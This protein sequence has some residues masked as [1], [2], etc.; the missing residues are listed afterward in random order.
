MD[1]TMLQQPSRRG[2]GQACIFPPLPGGQPSDDEA[3]T[4]SVDWHDEMAAT[5]ND[6]NAAWCIL[7]YLYSDT[8]EVCFGCQRSGDGGRA[9]SSVLSYTIRESDTLGEIATALSNSDGVREKLD[10]SSNVS[11]NTSTRFTA[12]YDDRSS[13]NQ[14]GD[15]ATGLLM[16][17]PLLPP[18]VDLALDVLENHDGTISNYRMIY[19]PT[20]MSDDEAQN[21]AATFKHILALL[22][23]SPDQQ[24]ATLDPSERDVDHIMAW[25][26]YPGT[27]DLNPDARLVH[28]VFREQVRSRPS[29]V[30]IDAWDGRL[31]YAELDDASDRLRDRLRQAGLA[32][33]D[34]VLLCF[35]KSVWMSVAMLAV[36]KTGAFCSSLDPDYPEHRVTQIAEATEAAFLVASQAQLKKLRGYEIS[37]QL[38]LVQVPSNI[39]DEHELDTILQNESRRTKQKQYQQQQTRPSPDSTAFV[40]F[41]SGSTGVPKGI[42]VSHA[43]VCTAVAALGDAFGVDG[44]TRTV[45][46]AAHSWDVSVQDYLGSLLRGATVCVPSDNERWNDLEGYM[47]RTA[48]NWA[49]LTPTVARTLRPER[50]SKSLRTLLLVGEPMGDAD[51]AGWVEAGTRAFNVYGCTEA[52]WVQVSRPKTGAQVGRGH[53]SGYGINTRVW[54]VRRGD[55]ALSPVGC[56]GEIWLEG[57]M[58]TQGY[59]NVDPLLEQRSFP[60]RPDWAERLLGRTHDDGQ[61]RFYRT[62]DLGRL[63][64]DGALEVMGR[65]DTQAKLGGQRLELSEVEHY[66]RE[67]SA[68]QAASVFIPKAG[69]F[70]GRLT[71]VLGDL[72][73]GGNIEGG[74]HHHHLQLSKDEED[75]EE[76]LESQLVRC[77]PPAAAEIA[78]KLGKA[79]PSFMVPAA[80]MSISRF[81]MTASGKLAR[82]RILSQLET[83]AGVS[84]DSAQVDVLLP[85]TPPGDSTPGEEAF[86]QH[87]CASLLGIEPASVDLGKSFVSLGGDSIRAMQIVA[88]YRAVGKRI[89]VGQLFN[90]RCLLEVAAQ[91]EGLQ[92]VLADSKREYGTDEDQQPSEQQAVSVMQGSAVRQQIEHIGEA[93]L[94]LPTINSLDDVKDVFPLSPMQ[95]SLALSLARL[96]GRF[97]MDEFVWEVQAADGSRIDMDRLGQAWEAVVA[98][99]Q[100]LRTVFVEAEVDADSLDRTMTGSSMPLYQVVLRRS[101]ASCQ[102]VRAMSDDDVPH[103]AREHPRL[104]DTL[105]HHQLIHAGL[106]THSMLMVY[107]DGDGDG[108]GR[109]WCR[110][111]VSHLVEDAMSILPLLRDVSLAYRY[112]T[113]GP[114]PG[115]GIGS[116]TVGGE[117]VRYI[118]NRERHEA[119]LAYWSSHL[120]GAQPCLFPSLVDSSRESKPE[121][122]SDDVSSGG[123]HQEQRVVQVALNDTTHGLQQAVAR[124]GLT[125]PTF[126]QTIWAL[127]L[128]IYS[129]KIDVVFGNV[130]SGRD[131]PVPDIEEA[132]GS[133]LGILVCRVDLGR[134]RQKDDDDDDDAG[135]ETEESGSP[136]G[137]TLLGIMKEIQR[138]TIEG[139]SNQSCSLAEMQEAAGLLRDRSSRVPLFNSGISCRPLITESDQ[140]DFALRFRQVESR[141]LTEMDLALIVETGQDKMSVY[142]QYQPS[143]MS[144]AAAANVAETVS[145]LVTE[146]LL[147]PRRSVHDVGKVSPRDLAQIWDWNRE[148]VPP[149][150]EVMHSFVEE[151]MRASPGRQA[152][153]SWDGDMTYGELDRATGCVAQYLRDSCGVVPDG[154]VPICSEKSIWAVV[155]MLGVMRA[156]GCF[157]MLD[158]G[159]PD[160]R[161]LSIVEQVRP[162]VMLSSLGQRARLERWARDLDLSKS[163]DDGPPSPISVQV[164]AITDD[165]IKRR[166]AMTEISGLAICICPEVRPR[167]AMY[168]QFTSGTTG[169]PKGVV[170]SHRNFA[171]GFRRHCAATE[172]WPHTRALQFSAYSFDSSVGEILTTLAV[173]GCLCS[174]SDED[175]SMAIVAFIARSGANWAAWTPSFASLIDPDDVPS[176]DAMCLAGEPLSASLVDRWADRVRMVNI[177]G[178]SEC[179]MAS[180]VNNPVT[181]D[182]LP[183]NIGRAHR[184]VTWI[185]DEDD[186]ERLQ[187]IGAVGELLIE[188]PVVADAGYLGRPDVTSRVFIGAPSWLRSGPHSRPGA[189][190]YKTGDLVRYSSDGSI[191]YVGRKDTQ[192]KIHGQRV[193]VGDIEQHLRVCMAQIVQGGIGVASPPPVAV[194]LLHKQEEQ[195]HGSEVLAAFIVVGDGDGYAGES[196]DASCVS[197]GNRRQQ[198]RDRGRT[199]LDLVASDPRALAGF[200]SLVERIRRSTL[201]LPS[202]M[203]PRIFVPLKTLPTTTAG[204][205]DRRA[206]H[207]VAADMGRQR[208]VAFSVQPEPGSDNSGSRSSS[209]AMITDTRAEEQQ[210]PRDSEPSS[211][212]D[213]VTGFVARLLGLDTV[214]IH[215]DFFNLGGNSVVAI[216]L[217]G[218]ARRHNLALSV[219]DIFEKPRIIDMVARITNINVVGED[220]RVTGNGSVHPQ[221]DQQDVTPPPFQLLCKSSVLPP[222]TSSS[223]SS[224][225]EFVR[226]VATECGMAVADIEDVFPCTPLQEN[227]M[228]ISTRRT[229]TTTSLQPYV[230]QQAFLLSDR[231][232]AARL[233]AA[234]RATLSKHGL[235]RSRIVST[236][237][238]G[239][240]VMAKKPDPS[241]C[242]IHHHAG[243]LESYLTE[244]QTQVRF[245]YGGPLIRVAFVYCSEAESS[246]K[247][248]TT[249]RTNGE[250]RGYVIFRAHHSIYDGW[251]LQL[252]W[253][254]VASV[255]SQ[256]QPHSHTSINRNMINMDTNKATSSPSFQTFVS[257]VQ[258][259]T[260][261]ESEKFWRETLADADEEDSSTLF[262]AVPAGHQPLARAKLTRVLPRRPQTPRHYS[263]SSVTVPTLVQAAW[264]LVLALYGGTTSVTFGAVLSGRD[265]PMPGIEQL[266]GPTMATVPRHFRVRRD[267]SIADFL[268][269]AHRTGLASTAHQHLGLDGI[270]RLGPGPRAACDFR[271][272]VVVQPAEYSD[273][274]SGAQARIGIRNVDDE[275]HNPAADDAFHPYPLNVEFSLLRDGRVAV[276]V[277]FDPD[278]VEEHRVDSMVRCFDS[279][280]RGIGQSA[281]DD[282]LA[283]IMQDLHDDLGSAVSSPSPFVPFTEHY[284]RMGDVV[285]YRAARRQDSP[286]LVAT[287]ASLTYRELETRATRLARRLLASRHCLSTEAGDDDDGSTGDN[288]KDRFVAICMPKSPL[289]VVAMLAI[290]KA[291]AAFT[292]LNTSHPPSRLTSI[293]TRA[294]ASLVLCSRS[295]ST[296]FDGVEGVEVWV[297][298]EES[299][300]LDDASVAE[301]DEDDY[302]VLPHTAHAN[303]YNNNTNTNNNNNNNTSI[304]K[305]PHPDDAA[306]LLFTSGSTG[307]PKGVVV[308][309]RAL[310]SGMAAQA[311]AI[312]CTSETRML[313]CAN[314]AFDASIL[315]IFAPLSVGGCVCLPDDAERM[316]D[317]AGFIRRHDV[318]ACTFTPSLLRLLDPADVP[319]L[320]TIVSGGEPLT[321]TDIEA[322]LGRLPHGEERHMYNVYGVTEACVVS[323]AMPMALSTSPRT[324]GYPVG[325]SL[326][327]VSPVSGMLAPPGAVGEL[328]LEGPALARGY[329]EDRPRTQ[330][331][332]VDDPA[333]LVDGVSRPRPTRV[334]R[335]G[336]L[337]Y[338]NGDGSL[339]FLGRRDGQVK[340]RGQ[341]V[342]PDEVANMIRG[343]I[344]SRR[345]A[346]STPLLLLPNAAVTSFRPS[347][348]LVAVIP[349][350]QP[351]Q[352]GGDG[353]DDDVEEYHPVYD[354]EGVACSLALHSALAT[355]AGLGNK[356]GAA[357]HAGQQ[358]QQQQQQQHSALSLEAAEL[359]AYL[360]RRI[361]EVIV[362]RAYI[363]VNSMP[364]TPSGKLD[365]R[366]VHRCLETLV[367]KHGLVFRGSATT[368]S[369]SSTSMIDAGPGIT[370]THHLSGDARLLQEC[371]AEVLRVHP[372][373]LIGEEADFFHMGGSSVTAIR[374]ISLL[375]SRGRLLTYEAVVMH[376]QLGDMAATL[377]PLGGEQL[378]S[379][380][381]GEHLGVPRPFEMVGG[382]GAKLDSILDELMLQYGIDRARVCDVYPCTPMQEAFMAMSVMHQGAYVSFQTLEVPAGQFTNFQSAWHSI[383]QRHELLRTRIVPWLG[384]EDEATNLQGPLPSPSTALQVVIA[385]KYETQDAYWRRAPDVDSFVRDVNESHGYGER[386]V[387]LA[388]VMAEEEEGGDEKTVQ[389]IIAAH[390]A[391]YDGFSMAMLWQELGVEMETL[392]KRTYSSTAGGVVDASVA[393]R[394]PPFSTYIRHLCLLSQTDEPMVFWRETLRG[395]SDGKLF[396]MVSS[397]VSLSSSAPDSDPDPDPEDRRPAASSTRSG[398]AVLGN[399]KSRSKFRLVDLAHAAW[400]L[401]VSHYTANPDVVFGV[402]SSGRESIAGLPDLD[403]AVL[404][405]PTMA[406]A[407]LRL[408]VDYA[409]PTHDYLDDVRQKGLDLARFAHVGLQRISQASSDARRACR[410]ESIVVVQP[411]SPSLSISPSEAVSEDAVDVEKFLSGIKQVQT[412]AMY[413]HPLMVECVPLPPNDAG[414]REVR[415][416]LGYDPRMVAH[417]LAHRVLLTFTGIMSQL[418]RDDAMDVPLSNLRGLS[419]EDEA[420]LLERARLHTPKSVEACVH[421]LVRRQTDLHANDV[422]VDAWDG[423]LTYAELTAASVRLASRLRDKFGDC[424]G[425]AFP[426]LCRKSNGTGIRCVDMERCQGNPEEEGETP[427]HDPNPNPTSSSTPTPSDLAY[428]LFTSGSTGTPKGVMVEHR[429]LSSSLVALG[430]SHDMTPATR[431]M[432]FASYAFDAMLVEIWSTLA[433]GGCVCVPSDQQRMNDITGF[434]T[435]A[436]VNHLFCTPSLS[437]TIPP[438]AV[439]PWPLQKVSLGGEAMSQGDVDRWCSRGAWLSNGYGP[440]EACIAS[441]VQ[442]MTQATPIGTVG[443]PLD[444]CR[445]WVVNPLKQQQQQQ[446]DQ[447]YHPGQY[448]LAPIGAIGELYIEGVNVARGYLHDDA[449]TAAAF[450]ERPPWLDGRRIEDS[451]GT[452]PDDEKHHRVYRTGDLAYYNPDG[453]LRLVGRKDAQVKLRGQRVELGEIEEAIRQRIPP[454]ITVAVRSFETAGHGDNREE[455]D[456]DDDGTGRFSDSVTKA[457]PR[458]SMLLA[459]FGVGASPGDDDDAAG[460]QRGTSVVKDSDTLLAMRE[461]ISR[462]QQDLRAVLPTYM[463]PDGYVPLQSLPFNSSGKLDER[464][465]RECIGSLTPDLIASFSSTS[466]GFPS[467][468]SDATLSE[469]G[470][471]SKHEALLAGLWMRLLSAYSTPEESSSSNS[472]NKNTTTTRTTLRRGDDFF[473]LGGDSITAMRL[474]ALARRYD[475][476]LTWRDIVTNPTLSAMAGAMRVNTSTNDDESILAETYHGAAADEWKAEAFKA[477]HDARCLPAGVDLVDVLPP[478]PVQEDF[479]NATVSFPGAH[480]SSLVFTLDDPS[481]DVARLQSAF[482]RCAVWFPILRTRLVRVSMPP[483]PRVGA[484]SDDDIGHDVLVQIV[485]AEP[486]AWTITSSGSLEEALEAEARTPPGLGQALSRLRVV[487]QQPDSGEDNTCGGGRPTHLIWTQHHSSY[488]GWSVRLLLEHVVKAYVDEAYQPPLLS[489]HLTFS[490]FATHVRRLNQ[491]TSSLAFWSA[492][493]EGARPRSL[494]N[495]DRVADPRRSQT[496][497]RRVP[498]PACE[499]REGSTVTTATYIVAAWATVVGRLTS[500]P[501]DVTLGYTLSGRAGPLAGIEGTVGPVLNKIPLRIRVA[502]DEGEKATAKPP[503]FSAVVEA[504]Q[505]ALLLVSDRADRPRDLEG[506]VPGNVKNLPLD[507]VVHPRGTSGG[508][509]LLPGASIGLRA[510]RARLAAPAP[511]A[512]SVE[513]AISDDGIEVVALWDE[514]AVTREVVDDTVDDFA[515]LL[516]G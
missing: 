185:V 3:R 301:E 441:T 119:S 305:S 507:L 28:E 324:V 114:G 408:H 98:R 375:R 449:K 234:W 503:A 394:R 371:W 425:R 60:N 326:W 358:R 71:A 162:R 144:D 363:A 140:E 409:R 419:A 137:P 374:L 513:V 76:A 87:V 164:L 280:C 99:H 290:W 509:D 512:F 481:L 303:A 287:G 264:A 213:I 126:F 67:A 431:T 312:R 349:S 207:R 36:L 138:A 160:S 241:Q 179:S 72:P 268:S 309:H 91:V 282:T 401:T 44:A 243:S 142:L 220:S 369:L 272:V 194:E 231:V 403:P 465:L 314:F 377:M 476:G 504:T 311:A 148:C 108:R 382:D 336:D 428:I 392:G 121:H 386:L 491:L 360:R 49:H 383:H 318:N 53:V 211:V 10:S 58:V 116:L 170:I 350:S 411:A 380:Q 15:T 55:Q 427:D 267:Q 365:A 471:L 9:A 46:F 296:V 242:T 96:G 385:P 320:R 327:L 255:Y 125:L 406:S 168:V 219:A 497:K 163:K 178:P 286:A 239:V 29:W 8:D 101:P 147:N 498:L 414:H 432:Q 353:D 515:A 199:S 250:S 467:S 398:T 37:Q 263:D 378:L 500:L 177:Y 84:Y 30:A 436:R 202:Y 501:H 103:V 156:G 209:D 117:F 468:S 113:E 479:M 222:D 345:A 94:S 35:E 451:D 370:A 493:L 88:R 151:R 412:P 208:L 388:W 218:M 404:A 227:L 482:D 150:E 173:G 129:G 407:P 357:L 266:V 395:A 5:R 130:A 197:D 420:L 424:R 182:S 325:A 321:R 236:P 217:S 276:E 505:K 169:A 460:E 442:V 115:S 330:T 106:P 289:A 180:T 6:I 278:C 22:H 155:A 269:H 393:P 458:S 38:G 141:E 310:C 61:H 426:I 470:P 143:F 489:D 252:I 391:V 508:V 417:E 283:S 288:T 221:K 373:T 450:L 90:S 73:M 27:G 102:R 446:D 224:L 123:R 364:V 271:S 153:C 26:P 66:L 215:D 85:E 69:P 133:F 469:D 233:R 284:S 389:V 359:D 477:V 444:S 189:R 225:D 488:D 12:Q 59:I 379:Q 256:P 304:R 149:G 490:A 492:Y 366:W 405:G 198:D 16:L 316:A 438:D 510:S 294:G 387:K 376:S 57:P 257:W 47:V 317:L 334:Y 244:Q 226:S 402:I 341:R 461:M 62:G 262:P 329:H 17:L 422:A 487:L 249:G 322:W 339:S 183:S 456:D 344:S 191:N 319:G 480:V 352:S 187:P 124:L 333:W 459:A 95:D 506:H 190:L 362:P 313:Q 45:Q 285:A 484:T 42:V 440:T 478:T 337:M 167:H 228:A 464:A 270:L 356:S 445:L 390:H 246:N 247:H 34:G 367:A 447:E 40:V 204:K 41:T 486:P 205:L 485:V 229:T 502:E 494:F 79:L 372:A 139:S 400:A 308:Q 75:E 154:V 454:S 18:G 193:E 483:R 120:E 24:V 136:H 307:E 340:I 418:A 338:R 455:D 33:G 253:D 206:L 416:N 259:A 80:W 68:F 51:I 435:T 232:D 457:H 297:L 203:I 295:T 39:G 473:K 81:P 452:T 346:S 472:N 298:E 496:M 2:S 216:R 342:E 192:L 159:H 443:F 161:L 4:A 281:P 292:P 92:D 331:S 410:F 351:L 127:V 210:N 299:L 20:L 499:K 196:R 171:T 54:I 145:H 78:T 279:L 200:R 93:L 235:L 323:A 302:Y 495:Y 361:P 107:H 172:V 111:E 32:P 261:E 475:L 104:L 466:S 132:F 21:V 368:T 89:T 415:V 348:C 65:T 165:W 260:G 25:H 453:S 64:A 381:N 77:S 43:N 315:E 474:V 1:A 248:R 13:G 157:V 223:S 166:M 181:R 23:A 174:P 397:P 56:R 63:C 429:S 265:T 175:R 448:E 439:M 516:V 188:G 48:V 134:E 230:T 105:S 110:L 273:S 293:V 186:H 109:V 463:V 277:R 128:H 328:F 433:F 511:G 112:S 335:T 245:D 70:A 300:S 306:Y 413:P 195:Q 122:V 118:R 434:I 254:E 100:A 332:F 83:M 354:V 251:S 240:L 184:S 176:L 347:D 343:W 238:G 275:E 437:R 396:P 274:L 14:Q 31:T 201:P 421:D 152:V 430:S 86:M 212:E 52:T 237:R 19:R 399:N 291:G 82:S 423:A 146:A 131:V 7:L 258:Q 355:S 384:G 50:T 158:P 514:R 214:G 462:L 74:R 97:Y 135:V 11:W